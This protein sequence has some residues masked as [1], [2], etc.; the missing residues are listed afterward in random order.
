MVA[1]IWPIS[2]QYAT[3]KNVR[4]FQSLPHEKVN[5]TR[6]S[7]KGLHGAIVTRYLASY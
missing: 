1:E 5:N 2:N 6:M 4:T 7:N 3:L